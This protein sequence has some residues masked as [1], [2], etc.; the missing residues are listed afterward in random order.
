MATLG[1]MVSA[2]RLHVS[3]LSLRCALVRSFA[4]LLTPTLC[5]PLLYD[6]VAS[7]QYGPVDPAESTLH[8]LREGINSSSDGVQHA[9]MVALRELRDPALEPLFERL[10]KSDDWSLRVDSLLGLAE[11]DPSRKANIKLIQALPGEADRESAISATIGLELLDL[12][13]ANAMLAWDEVPTSARVLLAGESRR[14]GGTPDAAMLIK[15]SQS[16]SPEIAGI[17]AAILLDIGAPEAAAAAQRVRD[18]IAALPPRARGA[19]VAQIAQACSINGLKGAAD[20]VV[21]LL[22]LPEITSDSQMRALGSLLVLAPQSAYPN[23]TKAVERDR[24]QLGLLR[25][26]A[27]L[28]ASGARAPDAV[29]ASLRNGEELLETICDAGVLL[30]ASNDEA[31]MAKLVRLRHRI[32]MVAAL[33]GAR[34]LGA[35]ADRALGIECLRLLITDRKNLGP[36]TEP[37]LRAI[38]R[39]AIVAPDELRSALNSEAADQPIDIESSQALLLALLTAGTRD[40]STV[41]RESRGRAS[42]FGEAIICVAN[43]RTATTLDDADVQMLAMIAGGGAGV[44]PDIRTQAAWLWTRYAGK[45]AEVTDA[46]TMKAAEIKAP[47]STINESKSTPSTTD[48]TKPAPSAPTTSMM[49]PSLNSSSR[50]SR[51]SAMRSAVASAPQLSECAS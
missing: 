34:R 31:A 50:D 27:V 42:R 3:R 24:S 41:A 2:R 51:S 30:A 37:V 8:M 5:L 12:A 22:E 48:S 39:L 10:L 46:L 43:A 9:A 17:A 45:A 47:A 4:A 19:A 26:A 29:W 25:Y 40:A 44:G 28:L 21:T 38:A 15:L 1:V 35:S 13:S 7:G 18:A 33:E 6:T 16:N 23:F 49:T 14:L 32:T 11:L 20:M 36:I